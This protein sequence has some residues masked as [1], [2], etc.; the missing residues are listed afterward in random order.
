MTVD[1]GAAQ[2]PVGDDGGSARGPSRRRDRA[3]SRDDL[4]R[5]PDLARHLE[6]LKVERRLAERTLALYG[7]AFDRLQRS[8]DELALPLHVVETLHVRRWAAR[9]ARRRG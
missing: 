5:D 6:Y 9:D 8:A 2:D 4:A 3:A 1:P 7:E